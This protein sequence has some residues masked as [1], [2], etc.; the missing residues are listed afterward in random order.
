MPAERRSR[1][2]SRSA[3]SDGS[4]ASSSVRAVGLGESS[5][6][7]AAVDAEATAESERRTPAPADDSAVANRQEILER[8]A[9]HE[10]TAD[11]AALAIR[12]L[13]RTQ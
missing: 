6:E 10:I 13:R 4:R 3:G 12:N 11:D 2:N 9:R 1:A 8:L 7:I 5:P